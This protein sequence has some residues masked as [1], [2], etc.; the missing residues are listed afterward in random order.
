MENYNFIITYLYNSG[1]LIETEEHYLIFDYYK[2]TVDAGDRNIYNGIININDLKTQKDIYVFITHN[3]GDHYNPLILTWKGIR[4]DINYIFSN[5][6]RIDIKDKSFHSIAAYETLEIKDIKVKAFGS[7]D[8]GVSFLV[9]INN[10]N[11]FHAGDLNWWHWYDEPDEA[12]KE[13][14]KCYKAEIEKLKGNKIDIAFFP[15]DLRLK[16]HYY[17]G[18]EYFIEAINPRILIPMHFRE[19]FEATTAFIKRSKE[20]STKVVEITRRGQEINI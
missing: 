7:T 17:L 10:I 19:S 5:D 14:E 6:I 20:Y 12:N 13:M 9:L 18:A 8:M 1:F 4:K 11:I 2:D 3:H 16:E 15:V